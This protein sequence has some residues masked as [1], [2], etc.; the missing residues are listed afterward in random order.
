[1]WDELARDMEKMRREDD[2]RKEAFGVK[3]DVYGFKPEDLCISIQDNVLTVEGCHDDKSEENFS[4]H[5]FKKSFTIPDNVQKQQFKSL[6]ARDGRTLRIE[7]PMV[8][9]VEKKKEEEQKEV[10]IQ[11]NHIKSITN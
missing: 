5:H 11:V 10:P 3:V 9:A 7:A 8:Q 2:P 4:C 1:M 6:L